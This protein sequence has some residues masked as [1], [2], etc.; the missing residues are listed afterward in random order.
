MDA[1]SVERVPAWQAWASGLILV[2]GILHLTMLNAHLAQARGTGAYFLVMGAAQVIWSCV[3]LFR[4]TQLASRVGLA[5]LAVAPVALWIMTRMFR[6]P[7]GLGPEPVDFVSVATA[8][9][10]LAAAVVLVRA[11]AGVHA[12]DLTTPGLARRTVTML[13]VLG[14]ALGAASY[15]G[16]M[17]A[18]ASIPWLG[19]GEGSHHAG[20]SVSGAVNETAEPVGDGHGGAH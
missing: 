17:A 6:S 2:S 5:L 20:A 18:E 10:E 13:V 15:G 12:S 8:A 16:A 3:A 11:R 1:V 7:W 19:E 4:P 14:M 9:L